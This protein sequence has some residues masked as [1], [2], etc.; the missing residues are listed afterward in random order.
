M[1]AQIKTE[2]LSR[3]LTIEV[4]DAA[5]DHQ[6]Q[7]K[8]K[9][10]TQSLTLKGF[11]KSKIP[12]SFLKRK[13]GQAVRE[14]VLSD[15]TNKHLKEEIERN[16]FELASRPE[17]NYIQKEAGKSFQVEAVFEVFPTYQLPDL[18]KLKIDE[19]TCKLTDK[20]LDKAVQTVRE[21]HTD[22]QPVDR[23]SRVGDQ[24]VIDFKGTLDGKAAEG[25]EGKNFALV[26]GHGRLIKAF[27]DQLTGKANGD[28]VVFP[29]K[30]PKDYHHRAFAN[31]NL[32]FEVQVHQVS[33]GTLPTLDESFF[34]QMGLEESTEKA[35]KQSI[36][37]T[38]Q[39]DVDRHAKNQIKRRAIDALVEAS[40]ID[41]PDSL[42]KQTFEGHVA[43]SKMPVDDL[44][45]EVKAEL[46]G[47]SRKEV[48]LSLIVRGAIAELKLEADPAALNDH[49]KSL[50]VPYIEEQQYI[51]WFYQDK[52]RVE[53][54]KLEVL[55][56]KLV[57]H[58]LTQAKVKPVEIA[59]DT[60]HSQI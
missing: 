41:L 17:V 59:F 34:K 60:I 20:D 31:K 2:G 3:R 39:Q 9:E 45:D 25:G 6:I 33:E 22:W 7:D 18:T 1:A 28:T 58:I 56:A 36:H 52:S 48:K 10:L 37:K 15:L 40:E 50:A 11:R 26:L 47:L 46:L 38:M 13:H 35:F 32:D 27:E 53:Q 21:K 42:V 54:A 14:E 19:P 44:T 23:E 30:F 12:V 24:M 55:E 57:D 49:I 51:Q 5:V 8:M 43:K 16:N 4:A 29:V